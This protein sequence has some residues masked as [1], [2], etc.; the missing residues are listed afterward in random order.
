MSTLRIKHSFKNAKIIMNGGEVE[1]LE[2]YNRQLYEYFE[3]VD[4]GSRKFITIYRYIETAVVFIFFIQDEDIELA[5]LTRDNVISFLYLVETSNNYASFSKALFKR[6]LKS[7]LN[8]LYNSDY[9]LFSGDEVIQKIIW[10][11]DEP[12]PSIY[13]TEEVSRILDAVDISTDEGKEHYLILSIIIYLGW[14]IS[15][16]V[17]LKL[18]S[19]DFEKREINFKTFKTHKE[20][21]Y[22]LIDEVLY[23]LIDY[24]MNVRPKDTDLDYV[25]IT[26]DKPYRCHEEIRTRNDI[27][28]KYMDKAGIDYSGRHHGFHCLRHSLATRLIEDNTDVY[29]VQTVLGHESPDTTMAYIGSDLKGLKDCALEV[30]Y[31]PGI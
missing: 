26:H 13:T 1:E 11:R 29:T 5:S 31:V 2:P 20:V 16:V 23:P 3:F 7:F 19:I 30:P 17:Y 24:L 10:H 21:S 25:F 28:T 8:W 6:H 4:D 22:V 9:I 12:L 14:R 15:D 27:V 18:S